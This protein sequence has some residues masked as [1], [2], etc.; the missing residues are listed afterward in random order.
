MNMNPD[1]PKQPVIV[2]LTSFPAAIP[3]AFQAIQSILDGSVLPNKVILY[4]TISQFGESGI[5]QELLKLAN[6]NPVFEIRN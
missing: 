6:D 3:Y 2:S 1:I 4:L 5:P